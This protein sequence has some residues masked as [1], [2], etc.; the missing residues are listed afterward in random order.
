MSVMSD[1]GFAREVF[2]SCDVDLDVRVKVICGTISVVASQAIVSVMFGRRRSPDIHTPSSRAGRW[3][4]RKAPDGKA[5][6]QPSFC[7]FAWS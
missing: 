6:M 1:S 2:L 7:V 3:S 5:Y 4:P